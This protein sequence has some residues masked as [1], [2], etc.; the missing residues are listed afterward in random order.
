[1]RFLCL[2]NSFYRRH[3]PCMYNISNISNRYPIYPIY[4]AD[5]SAHF[6][7]FSFRN[8][9]KSTWEA[10][11]INVP[12]P[13]LRKLMGGANWS[14]VFQPVLEAKIGTTATP[15]NWWAGGPAHWCSVLCV[16]HAGQNVPPIAAPCACNAE[17]QHALFRNTNWHSC[18]LRHNS[19][20]CLG[21]AP[22]LRPW[23]GV[24]STL[25]CLDICTS[26]LSVKK[27]W[28]VI[29]KVLPSRFDCW[30]FEGCH[31]GLWAAAANYILPCGGNYRK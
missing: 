1:M 9:Q 18:L 16:G 12:T 23:S 25:W 19:V 6:E 31:M 20:H 4:P 22:G 5:T 30:G 3:V 2:I 14:Q 26:K 7:F 21:C 24:A 27:L 17:N 10:I 11:V 28:H 13:C 15:S 29:W 8:R